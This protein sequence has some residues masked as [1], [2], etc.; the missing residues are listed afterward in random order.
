MIKTMVPAIKFSPQVNEYIRNRLWLLTGVL[1]R[2][3]YHGA[4]D[5][6]VEFWHSIIEVTK[7]ARLFLEEQSG[8]YNKHPSIAEVN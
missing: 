6:E 5:N 7:Q 3:E 8:L 2:K 4:N 1:T